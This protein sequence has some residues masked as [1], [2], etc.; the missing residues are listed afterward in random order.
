MM[1]RLKLSDKILIGFGA[2]VF[3]AVTFLLFWV[4][5]TLNAM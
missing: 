1:K 2:S 4:N 3:V 5:A